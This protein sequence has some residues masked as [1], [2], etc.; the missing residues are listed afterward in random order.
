MAT[1]EVR[2][3]GPERASPVD[4]EATSHRQHL[5]THEARGGRP[6]GDADDEHDGPDAALE[7]R[8]QHDGRGQERDDEEPVGDSHERGVGPLAEE[9]RGDAHQGTD[10]DG[11]QR[12]R[13][14]QEQDRRGE[15]VMSMVCQGCI[16]SGGKD[17]LVL[18]KC[19][20][21]AFM[22]KDGAAGGGAGGSDGQSGQ[23]GGGQPASRVATVNLPAGGGAGGAAG[24]AS[25]G[26]SNSS[27]SAGTPGSVVSNG[28][29]GAGGSGTGATG[30][31]GG[32]GGTPGSAGS[33]GT[34]G[35]GTGT[36]SNAGLGG[37]AGYSITGWSNVNLVVVGTIY[38]P[39]L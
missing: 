31:A 23:A 7:H 18:L 12:G 8:C 16:V 35:S 11:E 5:R 26:S 22:G 21:K 1:D 14:A 2:A 20:E 38:G 29:G 6:R 34:N 30:G 25:G 37:A 10:D 3:A 13:E 4:V 27:G 36:A 15:A 19:A 28:L 33:A 32:A 9:P 24:A 39:L 17:S